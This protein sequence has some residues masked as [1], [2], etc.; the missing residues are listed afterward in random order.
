M[1]ALQEHLLEHSKSAPIQRTVL[2]DLTASTLELPDVVRVRK[3]GKEWPV[4]AQNMIALSIAKHLYGDAQG[5][6]ALLVSTTNT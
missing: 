1:S 5:S 4:L 6:Q 2:P 3:G